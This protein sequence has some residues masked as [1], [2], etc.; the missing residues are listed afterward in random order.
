MKTDKDVE[1]A[2]S[3]NITVT[4]SHVGTHRKLEVRHLQMIAIGASIG[5][6]LFLAS[7][8]TIANAGAL[9]ALVAY[10][11]AGAC[12]FFVV[13][14]L[15]EMATLIPTSGSFNEY[16]SRFVDPALG[17]TSGWIY[18]F[19]CTISI[20]IEL[21]ACA[22]FL[23]FWLPDVDQYV[24]M[25]I[26]LVFLT[27]V[28]CLAVKGFGE[29]EYWLSLI[30][31]YS[32]CLANLLV[33]IICQRNKGLNAYHEAGGPFLGKPASTASINTFKALI[34]AIFAFSGTELVGVTAGEA[35]N[36]RKSVPKAI[37]G[38]F[39]RIMI[40]YIV[41]IFLIGLLIPANSPALVGEDDDLGSSP[42]VMALNMAKLAGTDHFMN[43][44][45][46]IAV[47]SSAN[48]TV[49]ASTRS[50][51]A[52]GQIG[53]APRFLARTAKNGVPY[54]ATFVSLGIG[55]VCFVGKFIGDGVVFE[56]L[57][58]I[59]GLGV[60]VI[61]AMICIVH[62]R[63]RKA[64]V[65]QG[66]KI[67]ELPFKAWLYPYGAYFSIIITLLIL[68]ISPILA[69]LAPPE[70][71]GEGNGFL[72]FM[73]SFISIPVYFLIYLAYKLYHK[74]AFVPLK[75]VD[76]RSGNINVYPELE[77]DCDEGKENASMW[78]KLLALLA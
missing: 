72:Q 11:I 34:A 30:K 14:S 8:S 70:E 12:V 40:F 1:T 67:E 21:I 69:A 5:T 25:G 13:H 61:W 32:L 36:P 51:M 23:K 55:S 46:F 47:F 26:V 45:C 58:N 35:K 77:G 31:I 7:G 6:G 74:T 50:L 63:F 33:V 29:I 39:W 15:G 10:L 52:L 3:Q 42:F 76:I 20:P 53:H 19:G 60:I 4:G 18:W 24:I 65:L 22:K 68:I 44:V 62:I 16:A 73:A 78:S 2:N 57:V 56:W 28:N 37:N 49:Y 41:S 43:F 27:L 17:F 71:D 75:Q 38:T 9:G 48:S 66:Y 59:C 54:W 64:Y